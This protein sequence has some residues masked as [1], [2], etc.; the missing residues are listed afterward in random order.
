M[1]TN[2]K[3]QLIFRLWLLLCRVETAIWRRYSNAFIILNAGNDFPHYFQDE[4]EL[5]DIQY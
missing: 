2:K 5:H 1:K 4:T 3:I